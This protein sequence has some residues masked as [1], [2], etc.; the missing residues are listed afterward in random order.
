MSVYVNGDNYSWYTSYYGKHNPFSV[1]KF[2]KHGVSKVNIVLCGHIVL[3]E[4]VL[5]NEV[6]KYWIW[7]CLSN[8]KLR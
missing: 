8:I 2:C 4:Q 6:V 5:V 3:F 7:L 1:K